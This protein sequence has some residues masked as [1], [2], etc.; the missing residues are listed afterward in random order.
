MHVLFIEYVSGGILSGYWKNQL[1]TFG[2]GESEAR[3]VF[4]SAMIR[5]ARIMTRRK[6]SMRRVLGKSG[7]MEATAM[8]NMTC[9]S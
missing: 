1:F 6:H 8:M 7:C 4:V 3:H 5:F 2:Q 9:G